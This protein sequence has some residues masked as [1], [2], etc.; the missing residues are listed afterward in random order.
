MKLRWHLVVL[1]MATLLPMVAF[2]VMA[3][4]LVVQRERATFERGARER[5]LAVLTAIDTQLHSSIATLQA[6]ASS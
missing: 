5:T 2:G 6:L 1:V 3:T 4:V